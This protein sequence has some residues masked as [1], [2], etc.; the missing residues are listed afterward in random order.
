MIDY[1]K[2]LGV[3]KTATEEEIKKAYRELAKKWHP[4]KNNGTET[5]MFKNITEAYNILSDERKRKEYDNEFEGML[6]IDIINYDF[7]RNPFSDV[8]LNMNSEKDKIL[9]EHFKKLRKENKKN[10]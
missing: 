10:E 9:A 5:E 2:I 6:N 4:D 3:P 8:S 7:S 1:Y